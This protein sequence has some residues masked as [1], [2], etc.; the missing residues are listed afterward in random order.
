[1]ILFCLMI[2]RK[3]ISLLQNTNMNLAFIAAPKS[4]CMANLTMQF[5]VHIAGH[6][7]AIVEPHFWGYSKGL[8]AFLGGCIFSVFW[9]IMYSRF[10]EGGNINTRV[11]RSRTTKHGESGKTTELVQS[12]VLSCWSLKYNYFQNLILE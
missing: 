1:M 8:S 3:A 9:K 2:G 4:F 11:G 6:M 10:G 7:A 5:I 12:H